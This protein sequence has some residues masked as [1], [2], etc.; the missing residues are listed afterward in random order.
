MT[1]DLVELVRMWVAWI[2]SQVR[3]GINLVLRTT[4]GE[5]TDRQ[6]GTDGEEGAERD[7]SRV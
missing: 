6:D 7:G 2:V 4:E 3:V 5:N 1:V